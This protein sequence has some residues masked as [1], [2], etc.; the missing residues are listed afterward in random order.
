MDTVQEAMAQI[1]PALAVNDEKRDKIFAKYDP[2]GSSPQSYVVGQFQ[3]DPVT[4]RTSI[5]ELVKHPR[6]LFIQFQGNSLASTHVWRWVAG[7]A[8]SIDATRKAAL[9]PA[10]QA[11]QAFPAQNA[12]FAYYQGHL[13]KMGDAEKR[14]A[15]EGLGGRICLIPVGH[16]NSVFGGGVAPEQTVGHLTPDELA[17]RITESWLA[18]ASGR[19]EALYTRLFACSIALP[20]EV[21]TSPL[22]DGGTR[23][24]RRCEQVHRASI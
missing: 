14:H 9:W 6:A 24:C 18:V 23:R 4:R 22:C 13:E 8:N 10:W 7:E 20:Q 19:I 5:T 15:L 3:D 11:G 2:D 21:S 1:L 16:G 12:L 17:A